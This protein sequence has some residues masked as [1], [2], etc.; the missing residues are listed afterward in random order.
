MT[1]P[2]RTFVMRPNTL[3]NRS[4]SPGKHVKMFHDGIRRRNVFFGGDHGNFGSQ[5]AVPE[6]WSYDP[7]A[8]VASAAADQGWAVI[9]PYCHG[10][11]NVTPGRPNDG[12]P[13]GHD[14]QTDRYYTLPGVWDAGA[15]GVTCGFAGGL[16]SSAAGS[17]FYQGLMYASPTTGLWT[18]V[19]KTLNGGAIPLNTGNSPVGADGHWDPVQRCLVALDGKNPPNINRVFVDT[20][21]MTQVPLSAGITYSGGTGDINPNASQATWAIDVVGR[22]GYAVIGFESLAGGAYH[23]SVYKLIRFSLDNPAQQTVLASPPYNYPT[24]KVGSKDAFHCTFDTRNR[25]VVWIYHRTVCGK[26]YG[27]GVYNPVTDTWES[28]PVATSPAGMH[29]VGNCLGYD[30]TNNVVVLTGGS[31]CGGAGDAEEDASGANATHY[32]LWRYA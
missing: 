30:P 16:W 12:Q 19:S 7:A 4:A 23:H 17:T 13:V 27:V 6:L 22:Y 1:I 31:F 21:T 32:S 10:P 18:G 8:D 11:G 14:A 5:S 2:L 20:V 9:S 15:D 29:V 25:R 26:V 28:I 24:H 3:V